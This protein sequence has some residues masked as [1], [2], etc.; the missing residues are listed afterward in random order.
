MKPTVDNHNLS[1]TR[2]PVVFACRRCNANITYGQR[3]CLKCKTT[4]VS[5]LPR[6]I[7]VLLG[8]VI[9]FVLAFI[10]TGVFAVVTSMLSLGNLVQNWTIASIIAVVILR[11]VLH[12]YPGA[13]VYPRLARL[14]LIIP[15][16]QSVG[17]EA[18]EPSFDYLVS[19][20]NWEKDTVSFENMLQDR[21]HH[22]FCTR[23]DEARFLAYMTCEEIDEEIKEN[24]QKTL[25]DDKDTRSNVALALGE[26]GD[27]RAQGILIAFLND[28]VE[29][30][31]TNAALA[32]RK[33]TGQ[34]F[35]TDYDGWSKWQQEQDE[36]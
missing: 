33:I 23:K 28:G 10:V 25:K 34:D 22:S 35:G 17:T 3:E 30:V 15:R 26:I 31:R 14:K 4:V 7:D 6:V 18:T 16:K 11:Y 21:S 36:K 5:G 12:V 13:A 29:A 2:I 27:K 20:K 32:L 19:A 8:T 9:W 24:V 1:A